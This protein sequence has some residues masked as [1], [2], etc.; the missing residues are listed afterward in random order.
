MSIFD[1]SEFNRALFFPR[2]DRSPPPAG[3][4][5]LFVEVEAARL[6]VRLHGPAGAAAVVLLFHG[7]GE[8]VADYDQSAL[9]F[10]AI[11]ARLAVV[12]YRGYGQ[13]SGV[14]T[15]RSCLHDAPAVLA[16]VAAHARGRPFFVMG[17]SL[18][19][20]CAAELCTGD[21]SQVAV[22]GFIFESAAAEIEGVVRRRGLPVAR[23]SEADRGTFD[24]LPKLARCRRPVLVLHVTT[25]V[26]S[27]G[28]H[29]V[30]LELATLANPS[31]T[32]SASH[33]HPCFSDG[34]DCQRYL[35]A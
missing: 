25:V 22:A 28:K 8:V 35:A 4:Q 24:P 1:S 12:D 30:K 14:P 27:A 16:A 19:G 10:A 31:G 2:P 29:A 21:R 20:A 34:R 9:R 6:H 13:S 32:T 3:A 23:I 17:R 7:N 18:G 11:G 15:L 5:D 33:P 26:H